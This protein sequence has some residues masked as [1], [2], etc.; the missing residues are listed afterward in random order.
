MTMDVETHT[1]S[2]AGKLVTMVNQV[3]RFFESQAHE[4][5]MLGIADHVAAFW[6]PRMREAIF[7]HVDKGGA[8]LRPLALEGLQ[9]LR[10]RPPKAAKRKLEAAGGVSVGTERGS[11][12]G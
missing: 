7:A 12:A 8:G 5:G 11:D 3:S 9:S 1:E 2:E 4:P 10:A 6:T